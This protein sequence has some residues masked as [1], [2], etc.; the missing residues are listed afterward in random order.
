MNRN[1]SQQ[2]ERYCSYYQANVERSYAWFVVAI[3]KSFD[4]L[5]FDRTLSASDSLFEFFVP[6]SQE[7]TFLALM[8]RLEKKS[9]VYQ[10]KKLP[11]RFLAQ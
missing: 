1:S 4:H 5:A 9:L 3:L 6:A 8:D 2:K 11:N 7:E 10:L